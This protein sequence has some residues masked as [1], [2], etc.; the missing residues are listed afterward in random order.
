VQ[1]SSLSAVLYYV[2]AAGACGLGE[3]KWKD[4]E[5]DRTPFKSEYNGK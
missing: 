5:G 2:K 3:Q 4:K 1:P